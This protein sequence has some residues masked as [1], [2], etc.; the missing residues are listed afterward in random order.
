MTPTQQAA[1]AALEERKADYR[2][3]QAQAAADAALREAPRP[4][5]ATLTRCRHNHPLVELS[6]QP[7]NGLEIRPSQLRRM[8][9]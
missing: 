8:A 5:A 4:I 6:S 7:F 9:Q 3:E 1:M 2:A